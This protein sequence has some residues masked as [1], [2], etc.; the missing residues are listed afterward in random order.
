MIVAT[1]KI[2]LFMTLLDSRYTSTHVQDGTCTSEFMHACIRSQCAQ[3]EHTAKTS[4]L[5]KGLNKYH[6][7][8]DDAADVD[9]T[10]AAAAVAAA[11]QADVR[12]EPEKCGSVIIITMFQLVYVCCIVGCRY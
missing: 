9:D 7:F 12:A 10:G 3:R 2:K 6:R 5:W 8:T 4:W 11:D 1:A